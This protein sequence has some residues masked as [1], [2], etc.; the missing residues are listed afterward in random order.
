KRLKEHGVGPEVLVGLCVSRSR[1]MIVGAL[2]ILRAGGAYL[3]LD[4]SDPGKRLAA[5]LKDAQ[6]QVVLV[7][8]ETVLS[9][10]DFCRTIVLSDH[11][12]ILESNAGVEAES[13]GTG[14]GVGKDRGG[15]FG[16]PSN[17]AYVIYTSGSA[18]KPKGV[19]ITH[20]SLSNLV[21]WHVSAF[22]VISE[23]R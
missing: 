21:R 10:A 16:S 8:P 19:E 17:L 22:K 14:T 18:G 12:D 1:A 6:V 23:D 9:P 3:P 11:G 4:P 15:N 7:G 20:G 5:L 2:G 13:T